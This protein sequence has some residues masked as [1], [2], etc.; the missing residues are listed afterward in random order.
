MTARAQ[1]D[2]R[3][4]DSEIPQVAAAVRDGDQ[5][6][7][8]GRDPGRDRGRGHGPAGSVQM[9]M[10]ELAAELVGDAGEQLRRA[11]EGKRVPVR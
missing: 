2:R 7:C 11:V 6:G 1:T 10:A 4:I 3:S 8:R 9:D 5:G